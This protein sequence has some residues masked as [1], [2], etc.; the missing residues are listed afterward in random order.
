MPFRPRLRREHRPRNRCRVTC[1]RQG[2]HRRYC[3]QSGRSRTG[4]SLP[5]RSL[6]SRTT[7]S[8][9]AAAVAE[10]AA[11]RVRAGEREQEPILPL[12]KPAQTSSLRRLATGTAAFLAKTPSVG[13]PSL[14]NKSRGLR[15]PPPSMT[16]NCHPNS[17]S[18]LGYFRRSAGGNQTRP[19]PIAKSSSCS[20]RTRQSVPATGPPAGAVEPSP[21]PGRPCRPA[22]PVAA[23]PGPRP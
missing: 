7:L 15:R 20:R 23:A 17:S 2:A 18:A 4:G 21:G 19:H 12:R 11:R 3:G 6:I 10:D 8:G 9:K 13:A 1:K 16:C 22:P 5:F 14:S